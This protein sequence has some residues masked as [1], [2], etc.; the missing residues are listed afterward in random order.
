MTMISYRKRYNQRG[1]IDR[2]SSLPV[3]GAFVLATAPPVKSIHANINQISEKRIRLMI[4]ASTFSPIGH[5][6]EIRSEATRELMLLP[7]L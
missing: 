1:R 2:S 4:N 7:P 6:R 3:Q 5:A